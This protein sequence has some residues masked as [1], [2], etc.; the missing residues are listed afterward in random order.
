MITYR[1]KVTDWESGPEWPNVKGGRKISPRLQMFRKIVQG[2]EYHVNMRM[3]Q[4]RGGLS[5]QQKDRVH[6]CVLSKL[7]IAQAVAYH[8][9]AAEI[10][11]R[12]FRFCRQCHPGIGFPVRMVV[13]E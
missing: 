5:G 7:H 11:F 2:V 6:P 1:Y 8:D 12:E 9:G 4:G 13:P 10:D 3:G